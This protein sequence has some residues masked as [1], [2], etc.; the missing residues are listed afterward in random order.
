MHTAQLICDQDP[1][2]VMSDIMSN[3]DLNKAKQLAK[4]NYEGKYTA[5][6]TWQSKWK[7]FAALLEVSKYKTS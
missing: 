6:R 2:H 7:T 1:Q 4:A 5:N 3:L